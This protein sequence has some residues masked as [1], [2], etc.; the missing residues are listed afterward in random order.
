[1]IDEQTPLILIVDDDNSIRSLL[2]LAIKNKGYRVEE[3]TNGEECLSVYQRCQPDLI[4]LDAI[5]PV[6]DGFTCCRHLCQMDTGKEV[7]ILMLTFLDDQESIDQAFKAGAT[8]Y[9]TKPIHWA[10]LFQRVKRLLTA[11]QNNFNAQKVTNEL[12]YLQSYENL[13]KFIV[14]SEPPISD[15]LLEQIRLFFRVDLVIFYDVNTQTLFK[16]LCDDLEELSPDKLEKLTLL[17]DKLIKAK[18]KNKETITISDLSSAKLEQI[19][20]NTLKKIQ[21]QSLAIYPLNQVKNLTGL[22]G[23]YHCKNQHSWSDLELERFG[24]ISKLLLFLSPK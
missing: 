18:Y 22:L 16:S 12:N 21:I 19:T 5:M 8:D 15:N 20:S 24:V 2:K 7:P 4:L 9:I 17:N 10:V 23:L 11:S 13:L 6:M 3:A 14:L 1:M